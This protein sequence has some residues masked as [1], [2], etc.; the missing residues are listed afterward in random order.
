MT[1]I[2]EIKE[3][4]AIL[5]MRLQERRKQEAA[6]GITADPSINIEIRDIEEKIE[7][8]VTEL[9]ELSARGSSLDIVGVNPS[10][11]EVAPFVSYLPAKTYDKFIGRSDHLDEVMNAMRNP[12]NR[13]I[14]AIIGLGGMGKTALAREAVEYSLQENLFEYIVW[15]S[16]KAEFFV[17]EKIIAAGAAS[18]ENFAEV[19]SEIGRQCNRLDIAKMPLDQRLAAV[20]YLLA[21]KR[22]LVALDNLETVADK[23]ALVAAV[24][25]ILGQSKLLLTSR[26]YVKHEQVFTLDLAGLPKEEGV[27][28]LRQN[29]KE[30]NVAT[31]AQAD[32]AQLAEIYTV[33]GG[34]PLAMKLVIGQVSRQP[35][36]VVLGALQKASLKGQDYEFYRFVYQHSWDALETPSRMALVDMSVFPPIT[37]GAVADVQAVSQVGEE[38]FWLAMDQLVTMSL[39]DKTGEA[40]RVRYALHPLTQYFIRSDITKEWAEQ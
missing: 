30:R 36:A 19:L 4:I 15:I 28:F 23:D 29:G 24:A 26:H 6:L 1:R 33:T 5:R 40:A 32:R 17:S 12:K 13:S 10:I 20:K 22:V 39:V 14:F 37:G 21:S 35:L 38:D 2:E 27:I 7:T 34:A 9:E 3:E 8:L 31:V 25:Q 16:F 18:S 11:E